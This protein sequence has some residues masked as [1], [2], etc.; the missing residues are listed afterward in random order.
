MNLFD[1]L[2]KEA[3]LAGGACYSLMG[4]HE[5]MNVQGDFSC[6][7]QKGFELFG[8]RKGRKKYFKPGSKMAI[9]MAYTRNAIMKIG[10]FV[11]VHGGISPKIASKYRLD[12]INKILHDYLIGNRKLDKEIE[13]LFCNDKSILWCRK[14]SDERADCKSLYKTLTILK[15]KNLVV[16][17]TPQD[18]GINCKCNTK[19]WRI[20]T[21]MSEAFGKRNGMD[22]I[23]VLEIINNGEKINI[24]K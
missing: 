3:K 13:K 19:V 9:R 16:A 23:Q 14:Y 22:R 8:G 18:D 24:L 2:A 10:D 5:L 17:H 1:N 4:N 15:A 20:D 7:S 21:A 11:F 6:V 12:E